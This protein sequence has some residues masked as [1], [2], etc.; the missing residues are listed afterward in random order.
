MS[1]RARIALVVSILL[2]ALGLSCSANQTSNTGLGEVDGNNG[3][4]GNSGGTAGTS[5]SKNSGGTSGTFAVDVSQ[6]PETPGCGNNMQ[7]AGEECDDG[8]TDGGDGCSPACRVEADYVCPQVGP[9]TPDM[10]GN[11]HLASFETCDDGNT[12]AGDGCSADCKTIEP[13]W[14][15]RVPGKKCVPLCGDGMLTGRTTDGTRVQGTLAL[16]PSGCR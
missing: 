14:E 1:L 11:G 2:I 12:N 13:G 16:A 4:T 3:G 7:D 15:C 6:T 10:C 9:C 8:N 5:G